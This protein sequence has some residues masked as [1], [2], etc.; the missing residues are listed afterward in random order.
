SVASQKVETETEKPTSTSVTS[1]E[2]VAVTD[3]QRIFASPLAKRLAQEKGVDLAD[4]KGSGDQGRIVRKDIEEYRPIQKS[5]EKAVA[6]EEKSAA[7]KTTSPAP[8]YVPV[9]EEMVEEVKNSQMRKV[10]AKRLAESKY[11]APHYY[12]TIEVDMDN[13]KASR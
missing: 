13:A 1:E 11:S 6:M 5:A 7:A 8:V 2:P 3:G 12:L 4:V 9:G 10:I